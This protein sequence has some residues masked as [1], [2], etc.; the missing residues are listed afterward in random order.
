MTRDFIARCEKAGIAFRFCDFDKENPNEALDFSNI[1]VTLCLRNPQERE[2]GRKPPTKLIN[3]WAAHTIP[4]IDREPGYLSVGTPDRDCL[5][6][7]ADH[8]CSPQDAQ[9]ELF[10]LLVKVVSND[11]SQLHAEIAKQAERF[12]KPAIAS[13]LLT[14]LTEEDAPEW[15][16]KQKM[17]IT[18]ALVIFPI[19]RVIRKC[20]RIVRRAVNDK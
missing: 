15:G 6:L 9:E 18:L 14:F 20:N 19:K 4:I 3:A 5:L 11:L 2:V 7:R 12:T 10:S 16:L 8:R 1:L 13:D 17:A